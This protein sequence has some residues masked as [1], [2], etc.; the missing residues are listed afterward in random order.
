M[1]ISK[2]RLQ[3]TPDAPKDK[4]HVAPDGRLLDPG[5]D[6]VVLERP[7][8]HVDHRGSLFEAVSF[9]H[10]FWS[11]PIVHCE[12]VVTAPGMI[13][14]WGMHL[15]S[16]D[17]YVVGAG[18]LRV[19]L[20]D[21]RVDSPS[22]RR[23]AQF[24]FSEQAP[25]WLRIPCGVWHASQNYGATEATFVNFPTEPYRFDDPDK[26]R[27]DPHDRSKIDFDWVLRGG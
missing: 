17:R 8:R 19:V 1:S 11:E 3:V 4:A 14:G 9:G 16:V 24:H 26:Y 22:Y 21:G 2:P 20:H 23:F 7:P 18:R 13:K 6:G 10:P 15:E 12:W 5:I 27:L 25:G